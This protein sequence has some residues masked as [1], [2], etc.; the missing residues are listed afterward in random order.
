V[1]SGGGSAPGGT[2]G[3]GAGGSGFDAARG[4]DD[5]RWQTD[6]RMNWGDDSVDPSTITRP[7]AGEIDF[8][9]SEEPA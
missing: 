7:E 1:A 2:G 3:A 5:R 8:G 9:D 4:P 6:G